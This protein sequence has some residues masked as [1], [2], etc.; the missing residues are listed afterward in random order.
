MYS[1][2]NKSILKSLDAQNTSPCTFL[3]LVIIEMFLLS[4]YSNV[5]LVSSKQFL[6][7]VKDVT[8]FQQSTSNSLVLDSIGGTRSS[9]K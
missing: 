8:R 4:F 9:D 7:K 5:S 6:L 1:E 3:F 2:E